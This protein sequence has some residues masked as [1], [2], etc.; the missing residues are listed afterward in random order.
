MTGIFACHH[1]LD[2]IKTTKFVGKQGIL[3]TK[4]VG[5]YKKQQKNAVAINATA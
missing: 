1:H 2:L 4:F 5:S 3:P